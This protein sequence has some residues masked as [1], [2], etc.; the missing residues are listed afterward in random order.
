MVAFYLQAHP[1]LTTPNNKFRF[2]GRNMS[3]TRGL[4][5][6]IYNTEGIKG[7]FKGYVPRIVK[8]APACAIMIS[9]YEYGKSFFLRYN[10]ER[11]L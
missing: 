10:K 11:G 3:T 1:K 6:R 5:S 9:T 4:M 7:L 8:V 2:T